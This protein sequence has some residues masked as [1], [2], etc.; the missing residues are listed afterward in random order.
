MAMLIL[1]AVVSVALAA[2]LTALVMRGRTA[3][4][5]A[6]LASAQ[7]ELNSRNAELAN[8][9]RDLELRTQE[10][11]ASRNE[12]ASARSEIAALNARLQEQ[13]ANN[14]EKLRLL[15]EASQQLQNAFQKLAADALASNNQS[16][17]HLAKTQLE[18]FQTQATGDLTARQE[19]INNLVKPL[20]ESLKAVNAQVTQISE[21][22]GEL[23][24][25]LDTM[26]SAQEQLQGETRNLVKALRAPHVRGRWGEIQLRRVVEI[27]GMLP[28]C[29]FVEQVVANE[30]RLR[31][32]LIVKL[33][34]GK[35]II[36]DS[37][38]PLAAYLDAVEA[39]DD[40]TRAAFL[41]SHANQIKKHMEQLGSKSY[42]DQFDSTPEFVIMFLPGEVFYSAA[43]E[44]VPALI[45][46]GVVNNVIPASPT[47]LI[48]LLKA[49]AYGWRQEKLAEN[50]Q[51]I[52][53]LGRDLYDRLRVLAEH[54]A[55]VGKNLDTAV[56]SYNNAVGSFESRVL[57][58]AR[59]FT[60][61]GTAAKEEIPAL[62]PVEKKPRA[63]AAAAPLPFGDK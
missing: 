32:D 3:A 24:Q 40:E 17:L 44:Q 10:L 55:K 30:S 25:Y 63:L 62:E 53:Q 52:S 42:W 26:K 5:E 38:A 39:K 19:A 6:Q 57:V 21:E 50:A 20:E 13:Q 14:E 36:V 37:K 34:G 12:T 43:L 29:D 11:A 59:K 22:R 45:E 8:T 51:Q 23:R 16:F 9:R 2:M 31:P 48:A 4:V 60:E 1:T 7:A 41:L 61:L 49:V 33:P 15:T 28:Y 56:T 27:A 18:S 47:T 46:Q 58:S 54:F 35:Q